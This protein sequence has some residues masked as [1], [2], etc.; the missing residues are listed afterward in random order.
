MP[1]PKN[2][3]ENMI[4]YRNIYEGSKIYMTTLSII[5]IWKDQF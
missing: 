4:L 5:I 1:R 3:I 2:V